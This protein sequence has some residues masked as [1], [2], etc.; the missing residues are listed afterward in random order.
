MGPWTVDDRCNQMSRE[1]FIYAKDIVA[2]ESV[3]NT[4][5]AEIYRLEIA[6]CAAKIIA[7]RI[8][9]AVYNDSL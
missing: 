7:L 9:Q 8:H 2:A 6:V 3:G 5:T 4:R 1:A